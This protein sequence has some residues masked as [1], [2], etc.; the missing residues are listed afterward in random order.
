MADLEERSRLISETDDEAGGRVDDAEMGMK[1]KA[2]FDLSRPRWVQE[3]PRPVCAIVLHKLEGSRKG[4]D[5][6]VELVFDER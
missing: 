6:D 2:E 5:Y 1:G 4:S 3:V